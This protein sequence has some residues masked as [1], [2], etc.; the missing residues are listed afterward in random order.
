[1]NKIEKT[2]LLEVEKRLRNMEIQGKRA[3]WLWPIALGGSWAASLMSLK[4]GSPEWI[5]VLACILLLLG[6]SFWKI[7]GRPPRKR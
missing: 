4:V 6:V 2:A 7:F 5:V 1:M 3:L